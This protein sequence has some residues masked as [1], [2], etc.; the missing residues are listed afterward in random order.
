MWSTVAALICT[1][2]RGVEWDAVELPSQFMEN[3]CYD[4]AT[5]NT[6]ARHYETGELLPEDLFNKLNA[7][8][9]FR[10]HRPFL[11]F[12]FVGRLSFPFVGMGKQ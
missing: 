7:A 2:I 1:G 11:S 6:F 8:R 12:P 9:T 3:F 5:I 4:R 10:Q